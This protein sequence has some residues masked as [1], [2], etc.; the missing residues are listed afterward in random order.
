MHDRKSA[1]GLDGHSGPRGSLKIFARFEPIQKRKPLAAVLGVHQ[2]EQLDLGYLTL[3]EFRS[4]LGGVGRRHGDRNS[5][6][7]RKWCRG[8]FQVQ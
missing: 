3:R 5:K 6:N 2:P 4:D 7:R 1:G 8:G